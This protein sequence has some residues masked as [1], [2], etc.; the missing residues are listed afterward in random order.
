M[1]AQGWT[2]S[3]YHSRLTTMGFDCSV[4]FFGSRHFA[5]RM[6]VTPWFEPT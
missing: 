1:Q 2:W 6:S 4:E 5:G 3:A